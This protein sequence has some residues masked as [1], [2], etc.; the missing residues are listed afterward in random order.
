MCIVTP[1]FI[2]SEVVGER[3]DVEVNV[4]LYQSRARCIDVVMRADGS[5]F[6]FRV[7][8]ELFKKVHLSLLARKVAS[9]MKPILLELDDAGAYSVQ[10][11]STGCSCTLVLQLQVL[12][13]RAEIA[14]RDGCSCQ[15]L[16]FSY[17][18]HLLTHAL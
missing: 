7:R 6:H 2:S 12:I 15:A 4:A 9:P 11:A 17:D 3:S 1:D 13:Q 10:I 14:L 5:Q 18:S 16:R 8:L